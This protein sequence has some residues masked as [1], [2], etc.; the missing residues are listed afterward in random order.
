MKKILNFSIFFFIIFLS[1]VFGANWYVRPAGG[2]Y[3]LENGTSYAN[4]WDGLEKV[5]W[6]AGGVQPGDTLYVCGFHLRDYPPEGRSDAGEIPIISGTSESNRI[7]VRGDY[8]GDLG[9]I[10]GGHKIKYE[11]WIYEGDYV[12]KIT[13][14]P[15]YPEGY[16][17][18]DVTADSW[19]LLK[20][21]TS[22]QQCKDTPGSSYSTNLNH[23]GTLYVHCTDN[24]DPTNRI[25]GNNYGY[26]FNLYNKQYIT[27]KN[28]K[29][30]W[31]YTF[32]ADRT[33]KIAYVTIDGCRCWYGGA[34]LF[35]I[36]RVEG[37]NHHFTINNCDIAYARNGIGFTTSA[38]GDDVHDY[39]I[40]NNYIHDI[41]II[42]SDSDAH[43]IGGNATHNGLIENNEFYNCGSAITF[44]HYWFQNSYN[45]TIR[46]NYVHD[47]HSIVANGRGIELN[48]V[49]SELD[50][51]N[52]KIYGNIVARCPDVGYR[53]RFHHLTKFYN[54][55]AYDCGTSFYFHRQ[56]GTTYG[57][58]I[59]FKNNISLNP[60]PSTYHIVFSDASHEAGNSDTNCRLISD[61]NIFF[62][63]S[64]NQFVYV[65]K[66]GQAQTNLTGWKALSRAG[67]AFDPQSLAQDPKL[68]NM[69]GNYAF[70]TDFKLQFSSPAIDGG[71]DVGLTQDRDGMPIP[72]GFAADIGA[73][74]YVF[75]SS[76]LVAN[77]SASPISGYAP[78]NVSFTESANG[79]SPPY[80]YNWTFGDGQSS[81]SQN[82]AHTYTTAGNY[83]ATLIVSDS[84]GA[85]DSKS[86]TINVTTAPSPL[87]VSASTSPTSGQAPLTVNFTGSASGGSNPYTYNWSFGD[88]QS[89]TSQNPSHTYFSAGNY[90]ATLTVTDSKNA[91]S[92]KSL[93]ISVSAAPNALTTSASAFPTS[94]APPLTVN[95]A[96]SAMGGTAPY[97]FNW[98]FGDGQSSTSQNP[99]HIYTTAGTFAAILNVTDS[100]A[101][102]A[103]ASV[104]I[105]VTSGGILTYS[106]SL[107]SATGAPAPGQGGTTNPS[108]GNYSYSKGSSIQLTSVPNSNYR[109]SRWTGDVS[110]SGIFNT[111]ITIAMDNNKSITANFCIRCGD[112]NGDLSITPADA[113][114][115]F[116][117]YLGKIPNPTDCE[118]ENADVNC[119]GTKNEP[120]ITPADA[121]A[122][123]KKYLKK[124]ELPADCSGNSRSAG[125][126]LPQETR[127]D[128]HIIIGDINMAAVDILTVP[129]IVDSLSDIDAFGFDMLFP[130]E[131]LAFL[132]LETAELTHDFD[133]IGANVVS[134]NLLRVGGFRTEAIPEERSNGV[135]VVLIFKVIG[136]K[137]EPAKLSII[138]TYD[139]IQNALIENRI[140]QNK[141]ILERE[142]PT[143]SR[144]KGKRYD[145]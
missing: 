64:G 89:S 60:K 123:F 127:A 75:S 54:N 25:V 38:P 145:L 24:G 6:G 138:E 84:K 141:T 88:G 113:Q 13:V 43:G 85:N 100:Q 118:K 18:Q 129:I 31:S 28:L 137:S 116:D 128:D 93:T 111:D 131:R 142:K 15:N 27:F 37:S 126:I 22:L 20:K 135:L 121:Q 3:G 11:T 53:C 77:L 66:I 79:G 65:D 57:L 144:I 98:I 26:G 45:I 140:R 119:S 5:V 115:A 112:I 102:T 59:E 16:F 50:L 1:P 40:S 44:Y 120:K 117:I 91:Q 81:T 51:S 109:F 95:F 68:E 12:W 125:L 46:W 82:P 139:D 42:E 110:S 78:L 32:G 76:P 30:Y 106:L 47:M 114:K 134:N 2:N 90:T 49:D 55:V 41:G 99:S 56:S 36:G 8:P 14:W 61:N 72:Q 21:T 9:I 73:Y 80:T 69:S 133:T 52:Y 132:R 63:I 130:S 107:F 103:N 70:P 35:N 92:S 104:I 124:D 71:T 105:N 108:P 74:E 94:G 97:A 101:Q 86:I 4:A 67:C 83:T 17:W 7:T 58:K 87:T 39:I 33:V 136:E 34:F 48:T 29:F 96:G 19:T 23:G 10:W 143:V 62:P 122:I